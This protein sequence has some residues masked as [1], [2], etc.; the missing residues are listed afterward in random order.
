MNTTNVIGGGVVLAA[1]IGAV[2][3]AYNSA[4]TSNRTAVSE[5]AEVM[6]EA[7]DAAMMEQADDSIMTED[8]AMMEQ[9]DDAIMSAQAGTYTT[10]SADKVAMAETGDV[11][12]FF[13]ASW[14]P[15]C[16]AL[17]A[18][19]KSNIDAIPAGVTILEVD[20]DKSNELRQK[21]GVTTQHTL[22]QIDAE[23]NL[24]K[25]WTGGNTLDAALA[26]VI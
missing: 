25:K 11:V 15:S 17:D 10:Y 4:T 21:Y 5:N 22:V 23:G 24:V 2:L 1:I 13:K 14:C 8:A 19:I 9:K 20:Y 26:Q 12:L 7:S 16:R 18:D 6:V 3:L